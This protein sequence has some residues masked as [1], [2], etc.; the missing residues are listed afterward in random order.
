[1]IT[2]FWRNR[3]LAFKLTV[4]ISSIIVFLVV[5]ISALT[6][7][8]ER[9]NF[10]AELEQQAALLLDTLAASGADSLYFLD[11][12]FLGDLMLNLGMFEVLVYGRFYD[13]HGR[14][15]ADAIDANN[16]FVS[17]PD[18]FGT[19]LLASEEI[20]FIWEKDRL[21][22]GRAVVLGAQTVGAVSV[23]L[24][25]APLAAKIDEVQTQG[26]VIAVTAV[27][28]GMILA[29]FVSRSI[30]ESLQEM[31]GVTRRIRGGDLTQRVDIRTGAEL[32]ALGDDFNQ[33]ADKLES[34]LRQMEMEI[35]ERKRAQLGAQEAEEAAEAA[36][37][38]KSVFLANMSHELRTPLNSI[39]GFS[40]LMS[41]DEQISPSDKKR[42]AIINRSGEY[43]LLL[44]NQVLDLSKIE[45]GRVS[46]TEIEFN[47]PYLLSDMQ[48]M[49]AVQA[50]HNGVGFV[51]ECADNLPEKI[52][53]DET[54]L[55]Q[56]LIN[57]LG[58]AFKFTEQG[59]VILHVSKDGEHLRFDVEDRGPGIADDEIEKVF[60]VF[61]QARAGR[62]SGVG[63]GLGLPLSRQFARLMGGDMRVAN[64]G[65]KLGQGAIF[66][67]TITAKTAVFKQT[68][69]PSITQRVVG[70]EDG[71]PDYRVLIVDDSHE[72]R[73][74]LSELLKPVGFNIRMATNGREAVEI[75]KE[76]QP[77]FIWMDI[78]MPVMDGFEATH[79]IQE[80]AN[81]VPIIVA[82][83]ASAFF[84][85]RERALAAGFNDFVRIPAQPTDILDTMR[86]H[87]GVRYKY[88]DIEHNHVE[89]EDSAPSTLPVLDVPAELIQQLQSATI[90]A[91]MATVD[92][93]IVS[94][95]AYDT[96]FADKLKELAD[97]YAY[98]KIIELL[99]DK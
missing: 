47:L 30:T 11:A 45:A 93:I 34:T 95:E 79:K 21:I 1:M 52:T 19:E 44:I 4:I 69:S 62:E 50:Q 3:P 78:Y 59:A 90:R 23:G 74:F 86:Q 88:M 80:D 98:D 26:L 53:A 20:Q 40:Q 67:F 27:L 87:A 48:N 94:I 29:N 2:R 73:Q 28:V 39:L 66:T 22:A 83:T 36:N 72:S 16:R 61:E 49:F 54:K 57:V 24:P 51:I 58:N 46:L 15:V 42:L 55:R 75:A 60:E 96:L 38:A 76:W 9:Q 10:R 14:I 82:I 31:A 92:S 43:L 63:T 32:M 17:D 84:E 68:P 89:Y 6:I 35:E 13:D 65:G 77:H 7:Q 85:E 81:N 91:D 12:D 99:A 37:R 97:E 8:R 64:I 33:M 18:P 71:Q 70:L 5:I 41:R 25:T 56:I